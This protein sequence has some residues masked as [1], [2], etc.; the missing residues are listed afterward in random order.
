MRNF[1]AY[2]K[3]PKIKSSGECKKSEYFRRISETFQEF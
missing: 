1:E 2:G 3:P